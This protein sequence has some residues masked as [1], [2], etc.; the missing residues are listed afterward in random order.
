MDCDLS[1]LRRSDYF[2]KVTFN[3][4]L[5]TIIKAAVNAYSPGFV[6]YIPAVVNGIYREVGLRFQRK[7]KVISKGDN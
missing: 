5:K 4:G 3:G 1:R 2:F 7:G 6:I